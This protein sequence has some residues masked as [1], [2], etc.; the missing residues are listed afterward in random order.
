MCIHKYIHNVDIYIYYKCIDDEDAVLGWTNPSAPGLGPARASYA[1]ASVALPDVLCTHLEPY[2]WT[3]HA[4]ETM[5]ETFPAQVIFVCAFS[6]A[7]FCLLAFPAA[8]FEW[9][10]HVGFVMRCLMH[11]LAGLTHFLGFS[12]KSYGRLI[13][14]L[15]DISVSVHNHIHVLLAVY[16]HILSSSPSSLTTLAITCV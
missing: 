11:L 10:V 5:R 2:V 1:T 14:F 8:W 12:V 4:H 3:C 16:I 9:F 13:N 15:Q 6:G 7:E